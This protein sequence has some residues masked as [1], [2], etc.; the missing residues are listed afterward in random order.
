MLKSCFLGLSQ[1]NN[2]VPDS[3]LLG[4]CLHTLKS[5]VFLCIFLWSLPVFILPQL[6]DF[7]LTFASQLTLLILRRNYEKGDHL[8]LYNTLANHCWSFVLKEHS[9]D[10]A[11]YNFI[12]SEAE[13]INE[14]IPFVKP[15]KYLFFHWFSKSLM[16]VY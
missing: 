10:S 4:L 5:Y 11:V 13:V 16:F 6:T 14:I 9:V 7:K 15:E 1:Y 2:P 8:L 12:A 3:T